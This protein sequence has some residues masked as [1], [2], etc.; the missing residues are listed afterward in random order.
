[1]DQGEVAGLVAG[2]QVKEAT[3]REQPM[4]RKM[5][6]MS[7]PAPIL[8]RG[9]W[10]Y[11]WKVGLPNGALVHYVGMT[12]DTGS[13]AAQSAMNRVSAHL[14]Q[15]V[16]S[17]ALRRYL[18]SKR[19]IEL[20]ACGSLDFFAYGPVYPQLLQTDYPLQRARVARIEK[21]LWKCLERSGYDMLNTQPGATAELDP[22]R[23]N[24]VCAAF[25]IPFPA[26][27]ANSG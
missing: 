3:S 6:H 10:L 7:L 5:H 15:N 21:E 4:D 12:G 22:D 16:R 25:Q 24:D 19:E 11:V 9:F 2:E 20:E 14:G 8:R 13:G 17:N 1:M 26:L 18:K 23:W 27:K